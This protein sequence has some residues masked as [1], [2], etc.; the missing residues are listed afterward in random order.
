M[1]T[2]Y[3]HLEIDAGIEFPDFSGRPHRIL[4]HGQPIREL[5]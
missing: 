4:H 5:V 3:R 1:A 2:I